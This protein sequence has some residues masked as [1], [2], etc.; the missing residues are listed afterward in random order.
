LNKRKI[1]IAGSEGL[2]GKS[3][4]NAFSEIDD[5]VTVCVD[6]ELGHDLTDENQV[7][8]IMK[9]NSDVK[10][11]INLFAVNPDIGQDDKNTNLT[12]ISLDSLRE[13]CE[14]NLI[15]LFSVCRAFAK[16]VYDPKAILNFSSIYGVRSPKSFI[17]DNEEKH[18]GYTITKHGVIGLTKHLAAYLAPTRVNALVPGGVLNNQ[19]ENFIAEYSKNVPLQRMMN[20]SELTGIVNLLCSE[21]SSYTT[22]AAIPVDGG[23][24]AW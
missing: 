11:I 19:D 18:I 12:N 16:Y 10:Y 17:Y 23:W 20:V 4:N 3:L 8:E 2:I 5:I 1:I 15:A 13:Y 24:T 6:K 21:N 22:G 14:I 7:I 9:A